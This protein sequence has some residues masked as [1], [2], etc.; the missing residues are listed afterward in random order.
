MNRKPA[1]YK[2]AALPFELSR[3]TSVSRLDCHTLTRLWCPAS[4]P[5]LNRKRDASPRAVFSEHCLFHVGEPKPPTVSGRYPAS[6]ATLPSC[7]ALALRETFSVTRCTL[8]IPVWLCCIF[9][10]RAGSHP[11]SPTARVFAFSYLGNSWPF[12]P[13]LRYPPSKLHLVC[14]IA[15]NRF[16]FGG[17]VCSTSPLGHIVKR[18]AGSYR[19][20]PPGVAPSL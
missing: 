3:H 11:A 9:P 6:G 13:P 14:A 1:A 12:Y 4:I 10:Q 16:N 7:P 18:C 17:I 2:A 19:L 15:P 20:K 5:D 8:T